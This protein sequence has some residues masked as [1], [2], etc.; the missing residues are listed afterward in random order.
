MSEQQGSMRDR[1]PLT[2]EWV[3][4]ARGKW[5]AEFVNECV[6]R[7]VAGEPGHFY[8]LEDGYVLGTPFTAADPNKMHELQRFAIVAGTR[9]AAF[10]RRPEEAGTDGAH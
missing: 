7:A 5:G 9:F 1:M 10:M 3:D 4:K 8:A 6:R 2:A